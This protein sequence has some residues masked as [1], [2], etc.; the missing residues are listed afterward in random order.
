MAYAIAM[1]ECGNEAILHMPLGVLVER[2]SDDDRQG[3]S[4]A[5]FLTPSN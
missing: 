3:W 1:F 4:E 2:D 5:Q